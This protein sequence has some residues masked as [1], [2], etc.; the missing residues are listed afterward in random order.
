MFN[1]HFYELFDNAAAAAEW[2]WSIDFEC[3]SDYSLSFCTT[4]Y[5][6]SHISLLIIPYNYDQTD[7]TIII[8]NN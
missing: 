1:N 3:I 6:Q 8:L 5:P 2:V 7:F 4:K